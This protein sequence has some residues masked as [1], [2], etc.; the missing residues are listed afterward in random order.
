MVPAFNYNYISV[1]GVDNSG[2]AV[3]EPKTHL[4]QLKSLLVMFKRWM[5]YKR[6]LHHMISWEDFNGIVTIMES[7]GSQAF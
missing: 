1:K 5:R 2:N 7:S 6:L 4:G 3:V